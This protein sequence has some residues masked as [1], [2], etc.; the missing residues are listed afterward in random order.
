MLN[1]SWGV[2]RLYDNE[3]QQHFARSLYHLAK[4]LDGTRLAIANDGWELTEGDICALHSYKHGGKDEPRQQEL[5]RSGITQLAGLGRLVERPLFAE[6]F[7]Y[8][9]Q[10]VML[11]EIGGIS[12]GR[13][14]T[15]WGYTGA[16]SVPDF[17]ECY[18]RLIGQIYDSQLLCGFCWTQLADIQQEKNGLLDE[19]HRPKLDM[20]QIRAVNDRMPAAGAFYVV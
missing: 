5:F 12:L 10:P 6:G 13:G 2:P 15:G 7:G 9:G 3:Q 18:R 1:E 14:E 4:G 19:D 11:T 8:Q 17:L 16:D 20:A